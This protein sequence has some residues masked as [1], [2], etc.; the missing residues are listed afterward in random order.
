[1]SVW[2]EGFFVVLI[3]ILSTV[4]PGTALLALLSGFVLMDRD[5]AYW[6]IATPWVPLYITE[7]ALAGFALHLAFQI[8]RQ[9][10]PL[11]FKDTPK[12]WLFFIVAAVQSFLRG[13]WGRYPLPETIRDSALCYYAAFTLWA[14]SVADRS[15][16]VK[17]IRVLG[18]VILVRATA[19]LWQNFAFAILPGQD[20]A[21][22]MYFSF[23]LLFLMSNYSLPLLKPKPLLMCSLFASLIFLLQVRT[24]W[25][26]LIMTGM[27]AG[28][29]GVFNRSWLNIPRR[30]FLMLPVGLCAAF[31]IA[32][33]PRSSILPSELA[34]ELG[35]LALGKK[36]PNVTTRM[37][38]WSNAFEQIFITGSAKEMK[39]TFIMSIPDTGVGTSGIGRYYALGTYT[40]A[41]K[42]KVKALEEKAAELYDKESVG[43][44]KNLEFSLTSVPDVTPTAPP[45]TPAPPVPPEKP[46]Y[47]QEVLEQKGGAVFLRIPPLHASRYVRTV[48]GIPFGYPFLPAFGEG[49]LTTQR[50]DPHNSL[51]AWFYRTGL[52]GILSFGWVIFAALRRATVYSL[53]MKSAATP[54][55][56]HILT[57]SLCI[58]YCLGHSL[59][60]V[61]LENPFKG[62]FL[63]IF[64]GILY[65]TL[66]DADSSQSQ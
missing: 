55:D 54:L 53:R 23:A 16:R 5:F 45:A 24:A 9:R 65:H 6:H 19:F 61:T 64:L 31:L 62:V 57:A 8:V 56:P 3:G 7:C 36:S 30:L 11:S 10:S 38:L 52:I 4:Q 39:K 33:L 46:T 34:T 29:A 27:L 44:Q 50:F 47:Q 14:Y 40:R 59:T 21:K 20:A 26:A 22:A 13:L 41:S 28:L 25:L 66:R 1:M 12:P 42:E 32:T 17:A 35:T 37:R 48:L 43:T 60:D 2:I 18:C 63:W 15:W 58:V 49:W 51:I